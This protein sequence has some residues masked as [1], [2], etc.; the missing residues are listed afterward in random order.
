MLLGAA[1]VLAA[2]ALSS[3]AA[4][5]F[6]DSIAQR[7]RACT[8]CHGPEGRATSDGYVPRLAGKP[9]GYL[10]HQLLNF[11]D[12]RRDYEPMSH[13][14]APLTDAYLREIAG[15]FASLDVAYPAPQ[16]AGSAAALASRGETL[17]RRGDA[18]LQV[19][20]C[21]QCH[22]DAM[23]GIAPATPG[24]L[25]LPRDY[26]NAQLGAWR[27]GKRHAIAP[28]CMA[29]V[30]NRLRLQD[31]GAISLWLAAQPAPPAAKPASAPAGKLPLACGSVVGAA[32]VVEAGRGLR[33]A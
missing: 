2:S 25:G 29:I 28:D 33:R 3:A 8:G 31:I 24:L 17:V 21:T 20:A 16:L 11:R 13:L 5:Q 18:S 26:L 10:F 23:M 12:G 30:A 15:Y 19:P 22:G 32:P 1:A 7:V 4:P 9:S 14:L 6:E 27:S